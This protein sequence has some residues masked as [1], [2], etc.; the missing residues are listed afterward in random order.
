MKE[1]IRRW[2]FPELGE[3]QKLYQDL[4]RAVKTRGL[5]DLK[6]QEYIIIVGTVQNS[7]IQVGK[8]LV[9]TG[10]HIISNY[11]TVQGD[12]DKGSPGQLGVSLLQDY[13]RSKLKTE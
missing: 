11:I 3:F 10:S 9:V 7:E 8:D 6:G 12:K 5:P 2:L 1:R 13:E 4:Q